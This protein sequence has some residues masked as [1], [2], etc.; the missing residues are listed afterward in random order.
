MEAARQKQI[1]ENNANAENPSFGS[2]AI[3]DFKPGT[4]HRAENINAG[5][6][7]DRDGLQ[8]VD[9]AKYLNDKQ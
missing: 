3:R 7:T 8:R 1:V 5:Q 2:S 4:V 6:V 9:N